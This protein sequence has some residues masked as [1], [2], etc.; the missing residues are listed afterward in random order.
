MVTN[1]ETYLD[2]QG[3]FLRAGHK[4]L[5]H[6]LE[7]GHLAAGEGDTDLVGVSGGDLGLLLDGEGHFSSWFEWS[8]G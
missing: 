7:G 1:S 2:L 4:L 5:A 8:S 6:S 3:L